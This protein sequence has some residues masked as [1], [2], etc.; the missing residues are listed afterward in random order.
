MT[1][2]AG[3]L[4]FPALL[5]AIGVVALLINTGVVSAAAWQR[6]GDLWPLILIFLGLVLVLNHTLP[7]PQARIAGLLSAAL[8]VVA[9]LG[10]A[11]LAPTLPGG[12]QQQESSEALRGIKAATLHLLWTG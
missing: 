12:S 10:Y 8:M 4:V 7:Q 9:A 6:L 1:R 11:I 2:R 3:G 5:I